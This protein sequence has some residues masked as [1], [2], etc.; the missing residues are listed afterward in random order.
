MPIASCDSQPAPAAVPDAGRPAPHRSLPAAL[1][2]RA[3]SVPRY[4][5][6]HSQRAAAGIPRRARSI[7]TWHAPAVH[8]TPRAHPQT[9]IYLDMDEVCCAFNAASLRLIGV[10]PERAQR[11]WNPR[12]WETPTEVLRL[13]RDDPTAGIM[14]PVDRRGGVAFWRNLEPTPWFAPMYRELQRLGPVAILSTPGRSP[15]SVVGKLRWLTGNAWP[16]PDR[17]ILT[18]DK[19]AFAAPGAILIDDK[20]ANVDRFRAAGGGGVLVPQ[21]NN[22]ARQHA[23]GDAAVAHHIV[24]NIE[25]LLWPQHPGPHTARVRIQG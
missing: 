16:P 11:V 15:D 12:S 24:G 7:P 10:D 3:Q 1:A 9:R 23:S 5:R 14:E 6:A 13:G 20:E 25:G 18:H 21:F 8:G 17:I 22:R 19:A 2:G 4:P